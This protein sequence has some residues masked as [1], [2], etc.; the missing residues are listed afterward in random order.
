MA[1]SAQPLDG[2]SRSNGGTDD[3]RGATVRA[4]EAALFARDPA[5]RGHIERASRYATVL[6]RAID[7]AFVDDPGWIAG[8][9]LHDVG[10]L[11]LPDATLHR[12]GPLNARD[13][14]L[15]HRHPE[16]GAEMVCATGVL[17]GAEAVVRCHH[18]RWDGHGYPARLLGSEIPLAAR[19]FMVADALDAITSDRPHRRG[20]SLEAAREVIRADAGSHFDPTVVEALETVGDDELMRIRA[21]SAG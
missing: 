3:A 5:E 4:L 21:D 1:G 11:A 2:G 15:L 8:F 16:M 14:R 13:W 10:K 6:A 12:R 18:E 7:P 19:V 9:R 20:Q 17:E